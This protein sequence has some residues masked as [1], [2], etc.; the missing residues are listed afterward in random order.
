VCHIIFLL[1]YFEKIQRRRKSIAG[2]GGGENKNP[3]LYSLIIFLKINNTKV[4]YLF[5][6]SS[7]PDPDKQI[8]R[9]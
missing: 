3:D 2:S 1:Q 5:Y 7:P 4:I 9:R 6:F 8:R